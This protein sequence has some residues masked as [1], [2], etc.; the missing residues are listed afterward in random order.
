MNDYLL[1]EDELRDAMHTAAA[2]GTDAAIATLAPT[3]ATGDEVTRMR[4]FAD[5]VISL[6]DYS[7]SRGNTLNGV[8]HQ[9]LRGAQ[10]A[11]SVAGVPAPVLRWRERAER[12]EAVLTRLLAANELMDDVPYGDADPDEAQAAFDAAI[13]DAQHAIGMA[14]RYHR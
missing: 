6:Y 9:L 1:S 8:E 4:A 7:Q 11:R 5:Y 14:S 3:D 2:A 12:L 13:K 10:H